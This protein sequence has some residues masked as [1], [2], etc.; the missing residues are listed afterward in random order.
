LAR[1][2]VPSARAGTGGWGQPMGTPG[3]TQ[4]GEA[5]PGKSGGRGEGQLAEASGKGMSRCDPTLECGRHQMG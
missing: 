1:G 2:E 4:Y 3:A 5:A